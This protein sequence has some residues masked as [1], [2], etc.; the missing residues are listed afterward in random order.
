[1]TISEKSDILSDM[2]ATVDAFR[3]LSNPIRRSVLDQLRVSPLSVEQIFSRVMTI[4]KISLSSLSE[5]LSLLK[6]AGMV[7]VEV[8][9]TER[10]YS[11]RQ[12]GFGEVLDWAKEYEQFWDQRLTRLGDY[13]DRMDKNEAH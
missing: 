4:K 8:R 12:E 2:E 5:H 9:A 1:M 3:C 13:L 6:R 10:I 11:L 7:E